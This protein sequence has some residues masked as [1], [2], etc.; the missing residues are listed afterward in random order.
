M[1]IKSQVADSLRKIKAAK[2][3][4]IVSVRSDAS[5]PPR[6]NTKLPR[7]PNIVRPR[8]PSTMPP[9]KPRIGL[10]KKTSIPRKGTK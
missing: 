3:K 4:P 1:D 5:N 9:L 7:R 2:A 10:P 6:P 8:P